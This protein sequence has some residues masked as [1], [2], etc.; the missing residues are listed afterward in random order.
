MFINAKM[1]LMPLMLGF[2]KSLWCRS[3]LEF[4]EGF[5]MTASNESSSH[6]SILTLSENFTE[7]YSD[8][9]A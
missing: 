4:P 1:F 7:V 8:G 9:P 2:P 3:L 6:L 5:Q